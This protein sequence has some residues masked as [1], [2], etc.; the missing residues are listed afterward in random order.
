M[1]AVMENWGGKGDGAIE[2][3]VFWRATYVSAVRLSP[4]LPLNDSLSVGVSH[5]VCFPC[6]F[7]EGF[8]S[9]G[10]LESQW[11]GSQPRAKD[12]M[13]FYILSQRQAVAGLLGSR[14]RDRT[15]TGAPT[16][17][18]PVGLGGG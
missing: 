4:G 11:S 2:G 13:E 1:V 12:V 15:V 8:R 18:M 16:S 9:P 3:G 14:L 5:D 6:A 7:S 10:N 17:D